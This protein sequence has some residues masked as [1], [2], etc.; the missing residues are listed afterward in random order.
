MVSTN[1]LLARRQKLRSSS[2]EGKS[3]GSGYSVDHIYSNSPAAIYPE[4]LKDIEYN[5]FEVKCLRS[6]IS[7]KVLP[8]GSICRGLTHALKREWFGSGS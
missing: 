4:V 3:S 5:G 8:G 2:G 6:G 1:E 7:F